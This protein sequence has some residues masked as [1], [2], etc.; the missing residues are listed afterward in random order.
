MAYRELISIIRVSNLLAIDETA[1]SPDEFL[2]KYG[3]AIEGQK[4]M[5][6]QLKIL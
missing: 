6:T 1:S 2:E 3:F 5:S 4:A